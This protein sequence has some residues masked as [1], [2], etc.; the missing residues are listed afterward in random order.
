MTNSQRN[1]IG[2]QSCCRQTDAV[3]Q[4][5]VELI[6]ALGPER[7]PAAPEDNRKTVCVTRCY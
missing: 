5:D 1:L 6:G 4:P 3:A 7:I 2:L